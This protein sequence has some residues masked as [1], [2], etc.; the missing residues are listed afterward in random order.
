ME[1]GSESFTQELVP[2][3]GF[4][5]YPELLLA[6]SAGNSMFDKLDPYIICKLGEYK[7]FQ[8]PVMWNAG[9][10][11]LQLQGIAV[12]HDIN[13]FACTMVTMVSQG[14]SLLQLWWNS[15][16]QW[17]RRGNLHSAMT[18]F[19]CVPLGATKAV[20]VSNVPRSWITIASL[21][22]ACVEVAPSR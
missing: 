1:L 7:R 17:R 11:Y 18:A 20:P 21:Q 2:S 10:P 16:F 14:Q 8:T 5:M 6:S 13:Q 3:Y 15:Y 9:A 22:M 19:L 4:N 12:N